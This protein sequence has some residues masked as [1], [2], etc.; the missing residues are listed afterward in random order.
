MLSDSA[1][2]NATLNPFGARLHP[3]VIWTICLLW[4][5][6]SST[7]L[8]CMTLD[9]VVATSWSSTVAAVSRTPVFTQAVGWALTPEAKAT[10]LQLVHTGAAALTPR[11]NSFCWNCLIQTTWTVVEAQTRDVVLVLVLVLVEGLD[12][13]VLQHTEALPQAAQRGCRGGLE[14]EEILHQWE[15]ERKKRSMTWERWGVRKEKQLERRNLNC[16]GENWNIKY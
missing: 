4:C 16:E 1:D 7:Q 2:A 15:K 6:L 8:T 13:I 5:I 9:V 3:E 11:L 12:N 10:R 14:K